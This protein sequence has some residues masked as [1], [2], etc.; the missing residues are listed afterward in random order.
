MTEWADL[1]TAYGSAHDVP[2]MIE[3]W[4]Q[5]PTDD[6][7]DGLWSYLCHQGT[8]YSASYAAI[9]LLADACARLA[10]KERRDALVLA[11]SILSSTDGKIV[12]SKE[13]LVSKEQLARL[14]GMLA[15]EI[16]STEVDVAEFIYL[17]QSFNAFRVG[18]DYGALFYRLADGEFEGTC[19]GCG[20]ELLFSVDPANGFTAAEDYVT[21]P[22]TR[23]T[24]I[25]PIARALT[26]QR[27]PGCMRSP[28]SMAKPK[29]ALASTIFVVL[30]RVQSVGTPLTFGSVWNWRSAL[31]NHCSPQLAF[32]AGRKLQ[33]A[34]LAGS[35]GGR[36]GGREEVGVRCH[37]SIAFFKLAK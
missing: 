22:E 3:A 34:R 32:R 8:V 11:G 28:P 17:S 18:P 36:R 2:R 29:S 13:R 5:S 6:N 20:C 4:V 26:Q 9:P 33:T 35:C 30:A 37:N 25:E 10:P 16:R 7:L 27:C 15:T 14:D 21:K 19:N 24:P 12:A 23:R 31:E 1:Q